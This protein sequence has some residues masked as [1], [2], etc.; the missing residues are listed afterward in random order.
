MG[1][2]LILLP[3]FG[4]LIGASSLGIIPGNSVNQDSKEVIASPAPTVSP[5]TQPSAAPVATPDA[6]P[7]PLP[8]VI[9]TP[10]P[11]STHTALPK[12]SLKPVVTPTPLST[13]KPSPS[14]AVTPKPTPTPTSIPTPVVNSGLSNDNTYIN[15]AGNEV[16]SPAYSNSVP[17]GATAVCGDGTYSFSQSRRGT[18]SHHGG[19]AQWL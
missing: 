1:P 5:S 13:I 6:T 14:I 12:P 18:C 19:V 17:A 7:T 11:T 10:S 15:S 16:H 3:I 2:W 8:S 4:I 9:P